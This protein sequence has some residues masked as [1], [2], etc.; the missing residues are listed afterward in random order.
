M[1]L[2]APLAHAEVKAGGKVTAT[3]RVG[4]TGCVD[5]SGAGSMLACPWIDFRDAA[6]VS[7][8]V[9]ARPSAAV[10]A[11]GALDLRL[12]GSTDAATMEA[13]GDPNQLQPWSLRVRD[14]WVGTRG[15]HFDFKIGAQRIAWGVANGISVVDHINPL[16]L[17]N[18]T[19]FDQRLSTLSAMGIAHSGTISATAVLIPFFVPAALPAL[20]VELMAGASDLFSS[21]GVAVGNLETRAEPPHNGLQDTAVAGQL[22]WNAP[23]V[24]LALSWYHGRDSLPQVAGDV[25]LIGFQTQSDKVDVGVPLVYP[26][27]DVAGLTARGELPG[28]LNGWMEAAL[29]LPQATSAQPSRNQLEALVRLGTLDE[30]PDP[31]PTTVTQDGAPF[32]RWIL[33][34]DREFGPVRLTGQW[35]HGFFTER[36]AEALKDYGLLAIRWG[37]VPAV[38]IDVSVAT[39]FD[40]WLSDAALVWLHADAVEFEVGGAWIEGDE[41]SAFGGL[42]TAS[43]IRLGASMAF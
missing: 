41:T 5:E 23:A 10:Q 18:P 30:I 6:V 2:A 29:V 32:P 8:W 24:D 31:Y 7:P 27:I 4:T 20:D 15:E 14:A 36:S 42:R 9:E 34:L 17:E 33:G 39:D 28:D 21:D 26:A 13:I 35:L 16:D 19:R 12:H 22:R 25:V 11:R 40:G 43:H 37:I 3:A 1:N 38:R